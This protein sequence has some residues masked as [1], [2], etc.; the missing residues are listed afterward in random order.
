MFGTLCH[1]PSPKISDSPSQPRKQVEPLLWC[2]SSGYRVSVRT[3]NRTP[4]WYLPRW[5]CAWGVFE[6]ISNQ[7]S[8]KLSYSP[9]QPRK[10]V[11]QFLWC[12]S[13]GYR[14]S[15]RTSKRTP[16]LHLPRW[17]SAWGVFGTFCHQLTPKVS[18]SPSK[19]RKQVEQLLWCLS[20]A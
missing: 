11:E 10:Q 6:T 13:S 8:P 15:V 18:G 9:S 5:I 20:A 16:F 12:L 4:F 7:P 3:T 14:G 17:S 1:Q 19:P 2:L